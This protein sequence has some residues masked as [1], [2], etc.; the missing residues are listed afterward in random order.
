MKFS[1]KAFTLVEL[2]IVIAIIGILAA[3]LFPSLTTYLQRARITAT[4]SFVR[5]M[6]TKWEV[7]VQYDFESLNPPNGTIPNLDNASYNLTSN[8][9]TGTSSL[10]TGINLG[11]AG[12]YDTN[13]NA[14]STN[15]VPLAWYDFLV[16]HWIRTSTTIPQSYTILN[17]ADA[18]GFRFWLANTGNIEILVGD[19]ASYFEGFCDTSKSVNDGQW[20][21]I[22]AHFQYSQ[23]KVHCYVDGKRVNSIS[24]NQNYKNFTDQALWIWKSQYVS[25]SLSIDQA[26]I[27]REFQ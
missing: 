9:V 20:H 15:I 23:W 19:G 3:A 25:F 24:I 6:K 26:L 11:Q 10:Q 12:F 1:Q 7:V 2:M 17:T 5:N 4:E 22:A 14:R 21:H 8:N 16:M 18:D 13:S 27:I